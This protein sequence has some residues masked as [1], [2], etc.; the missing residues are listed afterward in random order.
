MHISEIKN[1]VLANMD[2]YVTESAKSK[3]LVWLRDTA[4]PAC[5]VVGESYT[6]KLKEQAANERGWCKFRDEFCLPFVVSGAKIV[7]G[8]VLNQMIA[9][10]NVE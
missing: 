8:K 2:N 10:T 5:A 1:M 6:N 7:I 3:T 9:K 4:L